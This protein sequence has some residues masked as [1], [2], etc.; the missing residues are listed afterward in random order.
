M[1]HLARHTAPMDLQP[2]DHTYGAK[3]YTGYLADGSG[4]RPAPGILVVHEGGGLGNHTKDKARRLGELGYV[5][6][7]MDL[8]G[9]SGF[10][11]ERAQALVRELSEDRAELRGRA[12]AAL[13]VLRAHPS[14]DPGRLAGIGFCFGGTTVLE[15]ARAGTDLKAVVGFHAG[16]AAKT[17]APVGGVRAKV[18]TCLGADD[19]IVSASDRD[20]F[21]AEFTTAGADWQMLVLGGVGHSFTN[22]EIDALGFPGFTYDAA[23]DRRSWAAMKALFDEVFA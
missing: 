22:P 8:F 13:E 9:E 5:A 3:T 10:G 1:R 20:A 7:A 2:L 16:L 12:T 6:F 14:V 4:G 17:P 15:L 23:A 18:L 19:P 21:A 11:L